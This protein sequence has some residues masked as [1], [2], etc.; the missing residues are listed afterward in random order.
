[1]SLTQLRRQERAAAC[2]TFRE[3][4]PEAPTLCLQWS[5][6]DLAGHLVI[7]ER[8]GGLPMVVA[9]PLRRRPSDH[10]SESQRVGLAPSPAGSGTSRGLPTLL[11]RTDPAHRGMD[12]SRR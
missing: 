2:L 3:L 11:H 4:G 7:S 12:P 1:M 8:Y 9:Y 6:A 5:A 10:S